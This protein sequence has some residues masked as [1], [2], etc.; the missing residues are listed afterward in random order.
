MSDQH[1]QSS[2]E[3]EISPPRSLG[4]RT[5]VALLRQ[6]GSTAEQK[7]GYQVIRTPK[8]PSFWWG[9][10]LLLE[11][12]PDADALPGWLHTFGWEFPEARHVALGLDIP[13]EVAL[14]VPPG[15]GLELVRSAVMTLTRGQTQAP[16][17]PN[18]QAEYRPLHSD[19]DWKQ[20]LA[21]RLAVNDTL[22]P[23]SYAQFARRR[24][25]LLREQAEAG[26]GAWF[27][28]LEPG[29]RPAR[30]VG[31]A[32]GGGSGAVCCQRRSRPLSDGGNASGLPAARAVRPLGGLRRHV[33]LRA[34]GPMHPNLL[35][36]RTPW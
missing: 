28:A 26:K 18:T 29:T 8:N 30:T 31:R 10:F 12:V 36:E 3:Q 15:A 33:G 23:V 16:P 7:S 34:A 19:A 2:G 24:L 20:A 13:G 9:N 14:D 27:G 5:D 1:E 25:E 32:D 6:A 11:G 17:H 21:L 22:E 4:F 35:L